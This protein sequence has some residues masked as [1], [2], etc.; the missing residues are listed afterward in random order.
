MATAY[1]SS[2]F[3]RTGGPGAVPRAPAEVVLESSTVAHAQEVEKRT[4]R[5]VEEKANELRALVGGSYRNLINSADT[6]VAMATTSN[7]LVASFNSLK[8]TV[9]VLQRLQAADAA[10]AAGTA[11]AQ[12]DTPVPGTPR[13][14][15]RVRQEDDDFLWGCR[16]K[17]VLDTPE[18]L[19]GL[20]EDGEHAAAADRHATCA[21]VLSFLHADVDVAR[22][23]TSRFPV[24]N[25]AAPAVEQFG[26]AI[27]EAAKQKLRQ[28]DAP[29]GAVA[30]CTLAVA[31][32]DALP[33]H[34]ALGSL[35]DARRAALKEVLATAQADVGAHPQGSPGAVAA[36]TQGLL[37]AVTAAQAA[38]CHAGELFLEAPGAPFPNT[39]H[40]TL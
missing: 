26:G 29:P 34:S 17:Y 36:A 6:I 22:L 12:A 19:W 30:D 31:L 4:L 10:V 16:V 8:G 2:A 18:L 39:S 13:G 21:S 9:D 40:I 33:A 1:V 28:F 24:V 32:V 15:R 35:L 7:A 5:E 25:T 37:A 11:G 3:S 38:V 20:L 27:R 23:V 14:R